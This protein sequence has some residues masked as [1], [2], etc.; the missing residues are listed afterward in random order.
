M[1]S[2]W[3]WSRQPTLQALHRVTLPLTQGG[4]RGMPL[5][6]ISHLLSMFPIGDIQELLKLFPQVQT[7]GNQQGEDP[8]TLCLT[9]LCHMVISTPPQ[10]LSGLEQVFSSHKV[11]NGTQVLLLCDSPKLN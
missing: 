6:C 9:T 8:Q 5:T 3:P 4:H 2:A 11:P 7:M 1:H 10:L